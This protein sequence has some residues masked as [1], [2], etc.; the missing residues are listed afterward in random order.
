M[1]DSPKMYSVTHIFTNS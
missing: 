1:F